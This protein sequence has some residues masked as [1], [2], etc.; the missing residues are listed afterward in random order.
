MS[1]LIYI[2]LVF[3]VL[4]RP[5]LA[6]DSKPSE[7]SI[8]QLLAVTETHKLLDGMMNQIDGMME[9]SMRQALQGKSLAPDQQ[10]A[11]DNMRA[12]SVALLKQELSWDSL[13]PFYIRM[14]RDSFT[15]EE[16]NGM[17]AFYKTPSGQAVIKKMPAVMQ[18]AMV[19]MQK[20]M[21]TLMPKLQQI[22]KETLAELKAEPAK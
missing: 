22:Q 1:K 20:R 18:G 21:G 4:V 13:E 11:F 7:Q 6:A 2:V 12:K 10:K 5:A 16:I 8:K 15:Q 17:L 19:E 14:Y 9:N 3:S